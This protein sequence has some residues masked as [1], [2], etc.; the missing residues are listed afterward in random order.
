MV[1]EIWAVHAVRPHEISATELICSTKDRAEQYAATVSIDPGVLAGA[2]TYF[3]VDTPGR[4]TAVALYIKGKRQEMPHCSDDR[5]ISANG[6]G[7]LSVHS[8]R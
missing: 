3:L 1:E 2:V 5:R 7:T 6:H 8:P 4:R